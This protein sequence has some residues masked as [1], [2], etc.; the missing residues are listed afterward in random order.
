MAAKPARIVKAQ[1]GPD[2]RPRRLTS[3]GKL[4]DVLHGR[5][6]RARLDTQA[7]FEPDADTP[8]L[9]RRE[10]RELRPAPR[11]PRRVP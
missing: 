4:G 10:L 11:Q 9:T 3:K 1:L 7:A 5:I 2:G 8:A 6:D